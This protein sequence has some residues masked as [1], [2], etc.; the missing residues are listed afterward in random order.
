MVFRPDLAARGMWGCVPDGSCPLGTVYDP[1]T[2]S[3]RPLPAPGG[4]QRN[5]CYFSTPFA[6]SAPQWD[7]L[8]QL[9]PAELLALTNQPGCGAEVVWGPR[10]MSW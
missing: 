1:A 10:E 6:C 9:T 8:R 5:V 7:S 4:D 3:C 2:M